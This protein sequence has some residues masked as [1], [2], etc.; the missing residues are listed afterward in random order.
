MGHWPLQETAL[1]LESTLVTAATSRPKTLTGGA[2][3]TKGAWVSLGVAKERTCAGFHVRLRSPNDNPNN[4]LVDIA[5]GAADSKVILIPDLWIAGKNQFPQINLPV[6]IPGNTHMSARCQ[7][8]TAGDTLDIQLLYFGQG[9]NKHGALGGYL[10]RVVEACG[11]DAANAQG[12]QIAD[13]ANTHTKGAWTELIAA[14]TK[15]YRALIVDCNRNNVTT[16]CQWL[17][18]VGVG[19]AGSETI[20]IGDVFFSGYSPTEGAS[21]CLDG[22]YYLHIPAGTRIAMRKQHEKDADKTMYGIV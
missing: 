16:D 18:D 20:I 8:T 9:W 10:G 12:T 4:Y 3:N 2:A 11:L 6:H 15:D 21:N 13:H 7:A 17:V 14:T 5:V 22:P 1:V 19:A